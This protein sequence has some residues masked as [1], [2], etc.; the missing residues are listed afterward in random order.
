MRPV[1][2]ETNGYV[3]LLNLENNKY[4]IYNKGQNSC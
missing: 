2:C 4:Y 3:L 1:E